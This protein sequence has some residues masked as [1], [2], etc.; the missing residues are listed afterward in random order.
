PLAWAPVSRVTLASGQ[1]LMFP[2]LVER[3]KPGVIGG[4]FDTS[5]RHPLAWAPVS[6]VTLASGQQLMFPH[7][8]ERAKPGVI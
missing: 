7:L 2:H 3:A 6:R 5:L 4:Q 1:Q 8:V